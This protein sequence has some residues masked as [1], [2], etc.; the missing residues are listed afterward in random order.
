MEQRD[1]AIEIR[2]ETVQREIVCPDCG[3]T[4]IYDNDEDREIAVDA[5]WSHACQ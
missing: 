2:G 3:A 4:W 1:A 5:L